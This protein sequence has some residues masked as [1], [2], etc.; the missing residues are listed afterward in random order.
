M[1]LFILE[2]I[3]EESWFKTPELWKQESL[4]KS[5]N[6]IL[7]IIDALNQSAAS[8]KTTKMDLSIQATDEI[9]QLLKPF[10]IEASSS[11]SELALLFQVAKVTIQGESEGQAQLGSSAPIYQPTGIKDERQQVAE[12]F[13]QESENSICA[14]CRRKV[15]SQNNVPCEECV[16]VMA[17]QY[18]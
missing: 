1:Y 12:V 14:R 6:L 13:F 18:K 5:S 17:S 4:E 10:Q 16:R 15:A 11:N 9:L 7:A 2:S 3:I 8:Q